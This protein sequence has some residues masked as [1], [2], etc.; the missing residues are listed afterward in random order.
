MSQSVGV[1]GKIPA[2]ADFVRVN[3]GELS[4]LGLDR[5]FQE[6]HEVVHGERGRL[7]EEPAFF[8]LAPAGARVVF[9]GALAPSQDAVGRVFPLIVFATL[10]AAPLAD[11]FPLIPASYHRFFAAAAA[12]LQGIDTVTT[13][14]L[15]ARAQTAATAL[16]PDRPPDVAAQLSGER[17]APLGLALGGLP[18]GAAYALRTLLIGCE[19]S[20]AA[21]AT[22]TSLITLDCPAPTDATRLFWLELLRRRL[23]WR[24]TLPSFIWTR[25]D[26]SRLLVTLGTPATAILAFLANPRHKSGRFWPLRTEVDAALEN[27]FAALT[28]EQRT[29]LENPGATLSDLLAVFG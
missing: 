10:D 15:A 7:P 6:A 16:S 12:L 27:A 4:R 1:Y 21:P 14:E 18:H 22:P 2:Q 20:R 9:L 11:G 28:P 25:Q 5:W 23:G 24:D 29:T 8:A 17:V 13:A 3:A 26:T 19:R